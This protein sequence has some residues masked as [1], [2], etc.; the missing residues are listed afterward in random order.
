MVK[1]SRLHPLHAG[2]RTFTGFQCFKLRSPDRRKG[3]VSCVSISENLVPRTGGRSP[4]AHY[5]HHEKEEF[6]PFLC[7]IYSARFT[8]WEMHVLSKFNRRSS[9]TLYSRKGGPETSTV[10]GRKFNT[11]LAYESYLEVFLRN[12]VTQFMKQL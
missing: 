7:S 12:E 6:L 9:M 4:D 1:Q 5:D 11:L 2:N 10:A 3:C 8:N